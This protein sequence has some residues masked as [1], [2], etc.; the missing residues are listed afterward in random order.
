MAEMIRLGREAPGD[1]GKYHGGSWRAAQ[2]AVAAIPEAPQWT[3]EQ[4]SRVCHR[5][6][7]YYAKDAASLNASIARNA[8]DTATARQRWLGRLLARNVPQPGEY[9]P[10]DAEADDAVAADAPRMVKA[11]PLPDDGQTRPRLRDVLEALQWAS[12]PRDPKKS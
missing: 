7:R 8:R 5:L 10:P 9:L 6:R 12:L 3:E 1:P 2:A 4:R 11:A